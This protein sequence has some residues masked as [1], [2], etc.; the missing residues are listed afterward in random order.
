MLSFQSVTPS[1][2]HRWVA[3]QFNSLFQKGMS[4]IISGVIYSLSVDCF[5]AITKLLQW[6]VSEVSSYLGWC[7]F[8]PYSHAWSMGRDKYSKLAERLEMPRD[9]IFLYSR[10]YAWSVSNTMHS[11]KQQVNWY[12]IGATTPFNDMQTLKDKCVFRS[13]QS[14]FVHVLHSSGGPDVVCDLHTFPGLLS[15]KKDKKQTWK[16]LNRQNGFRT[17]LK[18]LGCHK[19]FKITQAQTKVC[20]FYIN[21]FLQVECRAIRTIFIHSLKWFET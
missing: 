12:D 9:P 21:P 19:D 14:N 4:F 16:S 7:K 6:V 11:N 10:F 2:A 3:R 8:L 18:R 13:R 1:A 5:F 20:I 17:T 15:I